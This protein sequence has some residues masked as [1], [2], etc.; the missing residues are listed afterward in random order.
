VSLKTQLGQLL[1]MTT[2]AADGSLDFTRFTPDRYNAIVTYKTAYYSFYLP[3]A[4]GL[5]LAGVRFFLSF[6]ILFRDLLRS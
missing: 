2:E 1:D 4:A 3:V 6:F 5:T